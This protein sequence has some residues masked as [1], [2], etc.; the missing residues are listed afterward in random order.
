MKP[1]T[2]EEV[3]A[4]AKAINADGLDLSATATLDAKFARAVKAAGLKLY[5]YTV[6]DPAVAKRM[7]EHGVDGITTDRPAWLRERLAK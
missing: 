3:I 2:A 5:V 4:K 6:N 1:P 7:V